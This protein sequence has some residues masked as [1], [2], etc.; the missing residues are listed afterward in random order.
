MKIEFPKGTV[1]L[2][3]SGPGDPGLLTLHAYDAIK[4][5]DV[6]VYDALVS[7]EVLELC[8]KQVKKIY[9]GKR[10]GKPSP[11]QEDISKKLIELAM[12]GN[13]VARL[14]GG[15]PFMFGR[16]AEEALSLIR[17]GI[18]VRII[19]GISAGF[20]GLAYSGIPLTHRDTNHSVTFLTGHDQFGGTPTAVDWYSIAH[21]SQVI[22]LYMA[23]KNLAQIVECLISSGRK[24]DE[25]VAVVCNATLPNQSVLE[26]SLSK[27]VEDVKTYKL[28]APAIICIGCNLSLVRELYSGLF[29]KYGSRYPESE[30]N[31]EPVKRHAKCNG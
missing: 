20:G 2:V 13:R 17:R 22:V 31:S 6:V 23:M 8:D 3:G 14:K 11:Q 5:A 4:N 29:P 16:G 26:S 19:P 15:D 25:Y 1:W 12:A 28:N 9:S 27:V 7:K 18:P 21:G 24:S 30:S 10:G